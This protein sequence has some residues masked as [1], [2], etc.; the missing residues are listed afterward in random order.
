M[1]MTAKELRAAGLLWPQTLTDV[2]LRQELGAVSVTDAPISAR[3]LHDEA[4]RRTG[5]FDYWR[6]GAHPDRLKRKRR[7]A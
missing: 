7:P 2:Q 4:E 1:A 6:N 3:M 5:R